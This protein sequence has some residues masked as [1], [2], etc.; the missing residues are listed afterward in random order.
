MRLKTLDASAQSHKRA[1]ACAH[2][3]PLPL[4]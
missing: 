2:H 4:R 3:A 1:H